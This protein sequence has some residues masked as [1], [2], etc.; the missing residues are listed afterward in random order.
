MT[1]TDSPPK[2]DAE[3]DHGYQVVGEMLDFFDQSTLATWAPL[4]TIIMREREAAFRAGYERGFYSSGNYF[5]EESYRK[6][7]KRPAPTPRREPTIEERP[8]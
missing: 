6:W 3:L 5:P 4:A 1:F 7:A 8:Y 2:D